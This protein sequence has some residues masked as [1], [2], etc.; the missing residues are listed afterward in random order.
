MKTS[1]YATVLLLGTVATGLA[2][3]KKEQSAEPNTGLQGT[4]KLTDRQCFCVRV[5]LPNETLMFTDTRFAIH[6]NGNLGTN[7]SY[8]INHTRAGLCGDTA[9]APFPV[10]QFIYPING[11]VLPPRPTGFTLN[12]NTLVLDYGSPCDAPRDTYQRLP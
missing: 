1:F 2:G 8:T 4:W 10:L 9:S 11:M 12:G 5:P 6:I 3:C 7:G